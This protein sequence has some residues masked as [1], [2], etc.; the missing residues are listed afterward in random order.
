MQARCLAGLQ[1]IVEFP[2]GCG[3]DEQ[4]KPVLYLTVES[5]L[6]RTIA[7]RGVFEP[8]FEYL[9][10]VAHFPAKGSFLIRKDTPGMQT[11]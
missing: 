4:G 2:F 3:L 6:F 7:S 10:N 9:I 5:D 8:K 1:P 11:R